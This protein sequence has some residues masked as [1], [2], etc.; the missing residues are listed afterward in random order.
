MNDAAKQ[1]AIESQS[2]KA[3]EFVSHYQAL[4][5]DPYSDGFSYGRMRLDSVLRNYLPEN[6][7]GLRLLDVGCGT[8]HHLSDLRA[9]GYEIAGIDASPE[10]LEHARSNNPGADIRLADVEQLP[11]ADASFDFVLCVEVLRYL[12]DPDPTIREL[13]RVLKPGGRVL[14]IAAPLF[15]LQGYS[16]LN[17]LVL[18]LPLRG[19][20]RLPQFFETERRVRS[21]F[22]RAG[23]GDIR[24]HGVSFG[25]VTWVG[26]L[27][28]NSLRSFLKCW[29][30]I[31]RKLA[32]RPR[33]RELA[34][35]FLVSAIRP[36]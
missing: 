3:A 24:V 20:T 11:F 2:R 8:G 7:D 14:A 4:R 25:P 19:F 36:A 5:E 16:L 29:E 22:E 10:M 23:F 35:M 9:R 13:A 30:P 32:D 17:R 28:P 26:R 6:G 31:D 15:N 27:L 1:W 12:P 21:R 34:N 18:V 33:T